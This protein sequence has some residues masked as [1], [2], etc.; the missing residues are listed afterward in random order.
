[1]V[2]MH[3]RSPIFDVGNSNSSL[4]VVCVSAVR[5]L[6]FAV[7]FTVGVAIDI[8]LLSIVAALNLQLSFAASFILSFTYVL[9]LYL[10]VALQTLS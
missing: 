9:H 1:M 10:R 4:F 2:G 3:L 6:W 5:S 8:P 7:Q